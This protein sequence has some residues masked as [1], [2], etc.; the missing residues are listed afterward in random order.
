MMSLIPI[1]GLAI[2]DSIN[3]SAIAVTLY[4]L[5]K[6]H[7][8]TQ[9]LAYVF[10]IFCTYLVIGILLT[11]GLASLLNAFSGAFE[12]DGAYWVQL[13]VGLLLFV[14]GVFGNPFKSKDAPKQEHLPSSRKLGALFMLG[15]GISIV[16]FATALPYLA[17]IGILTQID[18]AFGVK[19]LILI[20]YNLVMVA[21]PL[22]LLLF[23]QFGAHRW[24]ATF[25]RWREKLA[26]Q[27]QETLYWIFG[28]V[29][30]LLAGN[31][32]I[33]FGWLTQL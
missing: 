32:I 6:K 5:T 25:S 16:E 33:H 4:L 19:V 2:I 21:P 26:K 30:F 31:A 22:L 14:Y 24:Q 8:T 27:A 28:I 17:A 13:I 10:G 29:G 23:A 12:S 9:V 18:I 11:L 1:F 20:A 3:P 7:F 15:V